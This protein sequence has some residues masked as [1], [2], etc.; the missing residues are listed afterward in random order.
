MR[1]YNTSP[2]AG[3]RTAYPTG[4]AKAIPCDVAKVGKRYGTW[5]DLPPSVGKASRNTARMV[6]AVVERKRCGGPDVE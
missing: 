5:A 6:V 2:R 4:Q 3:Q 1:Y